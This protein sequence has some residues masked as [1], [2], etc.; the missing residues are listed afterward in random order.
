LELEPEKEEGE[1][2]EE[3]EDEGEKEEDEVIEPIFRKVVPN[4][5]TYWL[6]MQPDK[7]DYIEVIIKT[8]ASGL[9]K[10]KSFERWS[11]HNDLTP[12]ADALEEWDEKV[13]D[14]WEEPDSLKLDPKTWI[15]DDPLYLDQ[16]V[17]VSKILDS[18]FSKITTFL[19]TFQAIL[20]IYWR[21]KQFKLDI[22]YNE[23]LMNPIEGLQN[24]IRLFNY[25][26]DLFQRKLPSNAPIGLINLNCENVRQK[27]QSTPKDYISQIEKTIPEVMR[28]R[29][30]KAKKWLEDQIRSL[31]K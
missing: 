4:I 18:A 10:I 19:S 25:Y 6:R 30:E 14:S 15:Q 9:D 28:D 11:K 7:N 2:E 26:H 23:A 12:Y 16:R 20:E 22:L 3:E 17:M 5:Q 13:G 21:N 1:E 29:N 24:T 27:I 8:F 31:E